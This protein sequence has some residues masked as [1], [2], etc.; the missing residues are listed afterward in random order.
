MRTFTARSLVGL[1]LVLAVSPMLVADHAQKIL[2]KNPVS[3]W[4]MDEVLSPV[5]VDQMGLSDGTYHDVNQ[6]QFVC[7]WAGP[8]PAMAFNGTSSYLAIPDQPAYQLNE[9]TILLSMVDINIDGDGTVMTK[10]SIGVVPGDLSIAVDQGQLRVRLESVSQTYD[11]CSGMLGFA[12]WRQV[13][14]TFG[15]QGMNLYLN[16][17]LADSNPYTGGIVGNHEM[18][19]LGASLFESDFF[20]GMID[21]VAILDR[22][23]SAAE[24]ADIQHSPEPG[25]MISVAGVAMVG[26][27]RRRRR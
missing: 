7:P 2:A 17:I 20:R 18:L 26:L 16:G 3:Y 21:E 22:S 23:L 10:G 13:A 25:T 4:R 1:C 6:G 24:I 8:Q 15:P 14:F 5:A 19:V 9:G 27:L 11:V 12:T